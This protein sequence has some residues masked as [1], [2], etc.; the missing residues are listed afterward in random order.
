MP[1]SAV[2][3]EGPI[4]KNLLLFAMPILAGNIA[5]SLNGSINAIWVG[6]YLGEAALTAA[7]NANSIMFFLIGSVFGIGMASTILIG[8]AMGARDIAQARKVMGTSA[9]FFG[10]LSALIAVLGWFLAPHL[11]TAMGT[12]PA[13]Q[14]LAEEYL[15]VIFLAMPLIYVFA[16]LSAALR[17]TGDAR[18][19]FRFLLVSVVLDIVFN[20]LL[21]FGLGPF[22]ALGIAGAAWA[23]LLAQAVALGGLLLY[24]RSKRHVLWLG[25]A[26][27]HLFRIAPTILRALIVK[28]VPMGLQM[29]LISLAM[30][31][32]MTLVNGFGTDTAAAYGAALQL[33]T[34]VQMPAMALGA[35][36]S[37]MAAQN[38]GAG[39]W[40]RVDATARTGI[41]A[42]FLMTGVLIGLLIVFDRW[43]L[44]LF[45]PS[46]SPTLEVARHL[47]H[48]GIWSFLLFGVS[49]VVSGVVRATGAVIPPLL[50]LAF[51]LWGVRV[52]LANALIPHLGA[53]GIWWSLPISSL[54]SM[55]LSLAYYRWGG[56]RKARMLTT[57]AD[58][59]ELAAAAEVPA[60]PASPVADTAPIAGAPQPRQR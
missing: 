34:Y 16:F 56:W 22:P 24:L 20:P 51:G 13:S 12:P 18:T 58:P 5:Q 30:I 8:Q 2:L 14:T 47:N 59:A 26:D 1:K 53:D 32:M 48:I 38:V 9:S 33:W 36:C 49:F 4:G 31:A 3:T 42:N 19:P 25:R 37:T 45:L 44:A 27:L 6:R 57:P 15:R 43:T 17:G 41:A 10:G 23:T 54:C 55:L 46:D 7:A 60:H 52:P 29:V 21:I 28:G 35:A 11:L 39:L 50:I 40:T